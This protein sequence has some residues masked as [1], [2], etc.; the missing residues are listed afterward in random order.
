MSRDNNIYKEDI[1]C[2]YGVKGM[3]WG[4]RKLDKR[5]GD[6]YLKKGTVVKRVA[7]STTDDT[8]TNKKYVSINKKDHSKWEKELG[9]GYLRS[10]RLTTVHS[11]TTTKDLK[12]MD[13]TKQGEL[14]T[15]M[16]M[17]KKFR[18]QANRDLET[19]NKAMPN[20]KQTNDPAEI[21]SRLV[22]GSYRLE[23]GQKFINEAINNG[24]DAMID[25]HGTNVSK[26]PVIVLNADTNL[27]KLDGVEYTEPAKKYLRRVY[28]FDI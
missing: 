21:V 18:E 7:T 15:K 5:D 27:S 16:L 19:Y 24:Y 1:L 26:T 10:G 14:Y 8:W 12:V 6:L 28:G 22:S 13:T 4:V 20:T 17:D 11:Y 9:E 23:S 3:K 2:H 25:T